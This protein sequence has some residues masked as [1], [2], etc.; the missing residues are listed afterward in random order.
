MMQFHW[1]FFAALI[2][3]LNTACVQQGQK[4]SDPDD[5]AERTD[6]EIMAQGR[7]ITGVTFTTLSANLTRA[8]N[9]DGV[10]EA[11]R[12]CNLAADPLVDSLS[13]IYDADIRRTAFKVRNPENRPTP[14]EQQIL[15]TYAQ[16]L[17]AGQS[18]EPGVQHL[19]SQHAR[20]YAPIFVN[21]LCL[22]C[23]GVPGE[24]LR[25]EDYAVIQELYPEDQATGYQE[26]DFRGIWSI[27]FNSK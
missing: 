6:A 24:T 21:A 8:L 14:E 13:R 10:A 16:Q 20:F 18:P 19:N 2:T 4:S 17:K 12:Y 25:S 9:N 27:E 15:D 3:V 1:L 23:H 22:Q 7:E 11:V 5:Q 26:G